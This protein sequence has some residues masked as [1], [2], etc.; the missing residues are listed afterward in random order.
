MLHSQDDPKMLP[1][2]TT[3]LPFQWV[4]SRTDLRGQPAST[5]RVTGRARVIEVSELDDV[6]FDTDEILVLTRLD[7]RIASQHPAGLIAELGGALSTG[8]TIAREL[9]VPAIVGL[10][11]ATKR[12]RNGQLISLDGDQGTVRLPSN[13]PPRW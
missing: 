2:N 8:A 6:T 12:I 3:R 1:L 13:V 4:S 10:A 5:G 11:S 7:A 9:G